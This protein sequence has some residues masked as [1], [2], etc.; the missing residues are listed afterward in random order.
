MKKIVTIAVYGLSLSIVEYLILILCFLVEGF[1]YY[2]IPKEIIKGAF[3]EANDVSL[4][5]FIFYFIFWVLSIYI[6]FSKFNMRHIALKMALLNVAFYFI[7]SILL[8]LFFPFAKEYFTSS[9]FYFLLFATFISPFV[10]R[11][12]PYF[13]KMIIK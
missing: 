1:I 7:F 6:F 12:L 8:S 13:N 10:L 2:N 5:R 4:M 3:R 11:V 9:F